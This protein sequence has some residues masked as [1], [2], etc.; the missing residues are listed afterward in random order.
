V[1]SAL[2]TGTV[3]LLLGDVEGSTPAWEADPTGTQ[4]AIVGWNTTVDAVVSR[5][6]GV[7]PVEQGEGD[8]FVAAF[9][10][11]REGVACALAIQQA[12]YAGPLRVRLGLHTGDVALRDPGNY[13]GPVIIR[14]AR[15]RNL[16]HGGQTVMSE[17]TQRLV[18]DSL[19]D[20][21]T[22]IDL[23]THRLKGMARP[24]RVF[25]LC[26]ED[27]VNAFPPLRS[28]DVP[29]HNL[30]EHR[31]TFIGR[32]KEIAAVHDLLRKE[33]IVTLTGSG[34]CG[35]TRIA[36]ELGAALVEEFPDGVWFV[37]LAAVASS[38]GVAAKTAQALAVLTG[39][40]VPVTDAIVAHLRSAT[41]VVVMDNCEH[42]LGGAAALVDAIC[43]GCPKVVVLAT[44]RQPLSVDGE[45]F[46]RLPSLTL[47]AE[48]VSGQLGGRTGSEAVELFVERAGRVRP[49]F[50]L[51]EGN[52]VAIEVIC[53]RLDGIPLAIELAA[54]RVRVLTPS[55]VAEG[56]SERFR[57]LAGTSRA[58]LPR[59]ETLLASLE[60][61]HALLSEAERILFRRLGAFAASFELEAVEAVCVG[62]G[63]EPWQILDLLTQL[64]DKSLVDVNDSG[65]TARYRLLE[66]MRAYAQ[67]H[68]VE[69]AEDGVLGDRHRDYYL[70]YAERAAPF[71]ELADP[72]WSARL[73]ADYA[74]FEAAL[75]WSRDRGHSESL[76]RLVG[77]LGPMWSVSGASLRLP[78][79]VG[80][81]WLDVAL[82]VADPIGPRTRGNLL[83]WSS[84][85][86]YLIG[87]FTIAG[88]LAE[89]G[90]AIGRDNHDD[91]VLGRA[92]LA[93][94]WALGLRQE[95]GG[96]LEEGIAACRRVGDQ[97]AEAWAIAGLVPYYAPRDPARA[98]EWSDAALNVARPTSHSV[99]SSTALA[100][101]GW[102][103]LLHGHFRVAAHVL[104][105]AW[106]A[107]S[108]IGSLLVVTAS[109]GW[110]AE[111]YA[112]MGRWDDAHAAADRLAAVSE[113]TSVR[114]GK[115]LHIRA[116]LA[117]VRGQ[118]DEALA[119]ARRALTTSVIPAIHADL[120]VI[121]TMI[122]LHCNRLED[123][124]AHIDDLQRLS[125][126]EGLVFHRIWANVLAA[127]ADRIVGLHA[128]AREG[129]T[130]A[131][132]SA[133]RL[134]AWAAAV[135]AFETLAGIAADEGRN[136]QAA[137][138][139]GAARAVRDSAGYELCLTSRE[140][141]LEQAHAALGETE[142][143][144]AHE[145]GRRSSV[146]D[147]TVNACN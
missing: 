107:G 22:L 60:W 47:P 116:L 141:D 2:P 74:E 11:A 12:L 30:P 26:H 53:R 129:A 59:Q 27:V 16:A 114:V 120:L 64:V 145:A 121:T 96:R 38:D 112:Y 99:P 128:G 101:L 137:Y 9:S 95:T 57:L 36:V 61:S 23:G 81:G 130:D 71:L 83:F 123:A 46:W 133:V 132:I 135:Y 17:A 80:V 79:S 86:H 29:L 69:A 3:T 10:R 76:C 32:R 62:N 102:L 100:S 14:A 104:D 72:V 34:G 103:E 20:G 139:F 1:V 97:F 78:S 92:L 117:S 82:A 35:K 89:E 126:V 68:L 108:E 111:A 127:G 37:D 113:R 67:G 70:S 43:S 65:A 4:E 138:L 94:A 125:A 144:R 118:D 134:P 63:V 84:H 115:D 77:A 13:V 21:A 122:E 18:A 8:S 28:V 143:V 55:Q 136:E 19:P 7:R 66:T 49:G 56:L 88:A 87:D 5:F 52:R 45:M 85:L 31:T 54:A 140:L 41:A 146:E 124:K 48:P 90:I 119:L 110:L 40:A 142:F 25:Q 98:R 91:A 39:P 131:L 51:D 147:A 50:E 105:D 15:L 6:D 109:G 73:D 58:A 106:H 33:R 44:S 24:E 42:V 75:S 93:L